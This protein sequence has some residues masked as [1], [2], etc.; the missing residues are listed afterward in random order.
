MSN[1]FH[2]FVFPLH[3]HCKVLLQHVVAP[4]SILFVSYFQLAHVRGITC[5]ASLPIIVGTHYRSTHQ[6]VLQFSLIYILYILKGQSS[7]KVYRTCFEAAKPSHRAMLTGELSIGPNKKE[8][9]AST[10][11]LC[12][13]SFPNGYHGVVFIVL[14]H[15]SVLW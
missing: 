9:I 3:N 4:R 8:I 2:L 10:T 7:W 14:L 11:I 1:L 12:F 15:L 5:E 6:T 13:L